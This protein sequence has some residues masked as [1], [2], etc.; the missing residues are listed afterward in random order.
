MNV[1]VELWDFWSA[2]LAQEQG[3][4]GGQELASVVFVF[5]PPEAPKGSCVG[6]YSILRAQWALSAAKTEHPCPQQPATK[7]M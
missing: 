2:F 6:Q 5:W 3:Q 4:T 1:C 7:T